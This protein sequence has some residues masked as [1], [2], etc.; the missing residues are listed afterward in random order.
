VWLNAHPETDILERN[1]EVADN[2]SEAWW[3]REDIQLRVA[4][5]AIQL[6]DLLI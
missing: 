4:L 5:I 6:H 1:Q 3:V 2:L